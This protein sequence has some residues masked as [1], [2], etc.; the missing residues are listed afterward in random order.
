MRYS[1]LVAA[2]LIAAP[3]AAE[4]RNAA[5]HGFTLEQKVNLVVSPEVAWRSLGQ[6]GSWW[7]GDHTY[8]GSASNLS[9]EMRSGGCFCERL[10]GGGGVEHLR[11]AYVEPGKRLVLTG[12][13]GPLLYEGVSGVMDLKVDR[14]AG[15]ST[16]SMS[17]KAGGFANGGADKLA[18]LV[19]K[20]LA[21]QMK[22]LRAFATANDKKL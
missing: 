19:D 21:D 4:V 1:F 6:I 11:V 18:P 20:V 2:S 10:D 13:L 17:Y 15:G 8:S 3:A 14:I 16:V 7:S 5:P 12:A 9:L 22:R